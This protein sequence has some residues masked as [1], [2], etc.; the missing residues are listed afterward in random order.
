MTLGQELL[1]QESGHLNP[2]LTPASLNLGSGLRVCGWGS[3]DDEANILPLLLPNHSPSL[4]GKPSVCGVVCLPEGILQ[5]FQLV[6]DAM[7]FCSKWE[8]SIQEN[9]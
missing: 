4:Q 6:P 8:R 9:K 7:C 1:H 5:Q 2:L 3:E